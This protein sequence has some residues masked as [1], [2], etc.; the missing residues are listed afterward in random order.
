MPEKRKRRCDTDIYA[1]TDK[2]R[3]STRKRMALMSQDKFRK[4]F[5]IKNQQVLNRPEHFKADRY[6]HIK[7]RINIVRE[8]QNRG[9]TLGEI[10]A[11]IEVTVPTLSRVLKRLREEDNG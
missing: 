3:E 5:N 2:K 11:S 8:M 6:E 1:E 10:A 7:N 9:A 4:K